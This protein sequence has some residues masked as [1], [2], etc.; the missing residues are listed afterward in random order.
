M[1]R[2]FIILFLSIFIV[3]GCSVDE[4]RE[5]IKSNIDQ[6]STDEVSIME[7]GKYREFSIDNV[8]SLKILKYTVAGLKEE[9]VNDMNQIKNEVNTISKIKV[10][11]ETD[12]SCEDNTT[13][14]EFAMNDSSKVSFEFECD[15]LVVGNKRY[16]IERN[17]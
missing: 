5:K 14:Y 12:R 9:N 11:S 13:I 8:K 3:L 16:N 10:G 2:Y 7:F 4:M 17:K 1:K 15:W 6:Y